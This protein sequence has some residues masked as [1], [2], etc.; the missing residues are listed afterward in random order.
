MTS[1]IAATLQ[2]PSSFDRARRISV[3]IVLLFD[4]ALWA[5]CLFYVVV[6]LALLFVLPNLAGVLPASAVAAATAEWAKHSDL[7]LIA[8]SIGRRLLLTAD[9]L[10][11]MAPTLLILRHGRRLFAGFARGQVFTDDAIAHLKALGFWLIVSVVLGFFVQGLFFAI[12]HIHDPDFDLKPLSL[13]YGAML[14]VAAYIMAEAR[15]IAADHAE[16]V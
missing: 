6:P 10:I 2:M 15:Q 11:A 1:D 7:P 14:Y 13:L 9:F 16:I 5:A 12:A 8:L 3:V 4:I